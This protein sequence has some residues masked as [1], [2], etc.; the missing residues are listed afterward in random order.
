MNFSPKCNRSSLRSQCCE[1]RLFLQ[2]SNTVWLEYISYALK[3]SR[4][5]TKLCILA[6][7]WSFF[8]CLNIFIMVA[9]LGSV[10]RNP[11]LSKAWNGSFWKNGSMK[12]WTLSYL[13]KLGNFDQFIIVIRCFVFQQIENNIRIISGSWINHLFSQTQPLI[14]YWI[15]M[16]PNGQFGILIHGNS[17]TLRQ[18]RS[19]EVG[20]RII[21]FRSKTRTHRCRTW[22]T[23]IKNG[24]FPKM[25]HFENWK[26]ERTFSRTSTRCKSTQ[27]EPKSCVRIA[28][29]NLGSYGFFVFFRLRIWGFSWSFGRTLATFLRTVAWTG[30]SWTFSIIVLVIPIIQLGD[31]IRQLFGQFVFRQLSCMLNFMFLTSMRLKGI[32]KKRYNITTL[33]RENFSRHSIVH[34][35]VLKEKGSAWRPWKQSLESNLV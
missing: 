16:Q 2:F 13:E 31:Q 10:W 34:V 3:S 24:S 19:N 32:L 27:F 25:D 22:R 26:V 4:P 23:W 35:W 29:T 9:N 15:I 20:A 7:P 5:M 28:I 18:I 8:I 12:S 1:M 6:I 11:T 17:R 21:H 14:H 33:H 30:R